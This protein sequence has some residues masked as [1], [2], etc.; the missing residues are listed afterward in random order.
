MSDIC[1]EALEQL[2]AY[3]DREVDS[4]TAERIRV[5]L[6]DC[7]PCGQSFEFEERLQVVIRM[8]M[9]EDVP[10]EIMERLR[11]VIRTESAGS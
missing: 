8:G 9:R 7:P 6:G 10:V 2:Y 4:V 1:R 3:L 5:H 11:A